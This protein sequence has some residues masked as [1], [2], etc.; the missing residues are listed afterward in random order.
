MSI[1]LTRRAAVGLA[2]ILTACIKASVNVEA[3]GEA[4]MQRSREWSSRVGSGDLETTLAYW[5]D[6]A[7][8]MPP[9]MPPVEGKAAIRSYVEGAS[10]IPGFQISWEPVSAHVSRSGDLAYLIERNTITVNDST[11]KPVKSYGK[12]V[13]VWRKDPDG[14]WRNVVDMWNDTQGPGQK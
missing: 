14:T 3:E 9:G 5:A 13:T 12:V 4:L 6:D 11:G 2:L 8:M 1:Q 10:K 7:V